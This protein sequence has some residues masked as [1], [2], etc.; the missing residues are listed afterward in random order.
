M[1]LPYREGTWFAVP[2]RDGGFAA[3]I[4][5]RA[6]K[7]GEVLLCYFFGPRRQSV[8]R[9]AEV[10]KL[11][12]K[13]ACLVI[14]VGDLG[15]IRGNWPIIGELASWNRSNW[16]MPVFIRREMLPPYVNWLV[17]LSDT[18]PAK[19]I[20]EE[21]TPHDRPDLREESLFGYGAA[22]MEL[23]KILK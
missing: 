15:L 14:K 11:P 2:L 10:E 9:L 13:S 18:D 22:E 6:A 3:G 8:P 20:K 1:K 7:K 19:T 21:R 12:A 17:F 4:V 16:P 23:S 5:A